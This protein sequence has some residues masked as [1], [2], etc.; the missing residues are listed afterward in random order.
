MESNLRSMPLNTDSYKISMPKQYPANTEGVFSYIEARGGKYPN[1]LFFGLQAYVKE[2]LMKPFTLEQI[3]FAD[4]FYKIHGEPF[5]KDAWVSM[6]NKYGGYMPVRIRALKEGTILP[7][8]NCLVTVENIDP[9]FWWATTHLE[10]SLLRAIWYGTTVATQSWT[11]K[12]I[13]RSY[14]EKT[15]DVAGL[16]FKLHDFG[17]R[18]VSSNESAALGDMA[19]LVNFL[20]TDTVVGPIAAMEYYN[21]DVSGFSIP[22]AEHSTITSWTRDGEIDAY[23]NMI[24][25]FGGPGK[26]FAVVSDSYDIYEACRMW[27]G[28]LKQEV[29]DSGATLIVRPDSGLPSEVVL[30]CTEIL[31]E[32]YGFT[33]NDKGYKVLNTVR[34]IQGDGINEHSISEILEVLGMRGWS[35]DNVAFGMGGALLQGINRDT[36]EFAMKCSAAKVD[37]EWVDVYKQPKTDS[38]KNS[39]RG[40]LTVVE[41]DGKI[42]TIRLSEFA[43]WYGLGW[44]DIMDNVYVAGKLLRDETFEEV[45]AMARSYTQDY[46]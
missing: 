40:R 2:Y 5:D 4:K 1:T 37:G 36:C 22:A 3:E 45:R 11:I 14:L 24:R 30:K 17:A 27:A 28:P 35:A 8:S 44:N 12:N 23:R 13:I 29:L 19:H 21:A 18:G 20:G 46:I 31:A 26:M 42:K 16:D 15:G 32:G 9:E 33:I 10:T 43:D 39:K 7:V 38:A 41:K 25:Q 34:V 6:F